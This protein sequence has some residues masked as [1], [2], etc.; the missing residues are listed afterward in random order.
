MSGGR[1]P[2]LLAR[3]L[4]RVVLSRAEE[5]HRLAQL[6]V[7]EGLPFQQRCRRQRLDH[8][9]ERGLASR[10]A[11]R[12]DGTPLLGREDAAVAVLEGDVRQAE[13]V[14]APAARAVSDVPRKM[15]MTCVAHVM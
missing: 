10:A 11:R 5:D 13:G 4:E 1:R 15:N 12:V 2:H 14:A 6:E 8:R 9:I 3:V 7:S